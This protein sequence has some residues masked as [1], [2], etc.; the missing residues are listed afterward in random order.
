V[1]WS[2]H[3]FYLVSRSYWN[4]NWN[5]IQISLQIIQ[6]FG[7]KK[8]EFLVPKWP[9]VETQLGA[10]PGLASRFHPF[11]LS[12]FRAAQP[13]PSM[14]AAMGRSGH[15]ERTRS[16]NPLARIQPTERTSDPLGLKPDPNP[17]S[18]PLSHLFKI[19]FIPFSISPYPLWFE[20]DFEID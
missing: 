10:E 8:K 14:P 20:A 5:W 17:S 2:V 1:F 16:T 3:L 6:R 11:P 9:W 15:Q 19:V 7:N 13:R 12:L 4:S 18:Y